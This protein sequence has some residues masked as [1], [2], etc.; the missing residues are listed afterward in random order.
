M[1]N[2][3]RQVG[4]NHLPQDKA[5][6][7]V[8]KLMELVMKLENEK[9]KAEHQLPAAVCPTHLDF[10][11]DFRPMS[12][13]EGG[14]KQSPTFPQAA[15]VASHESLNSMKLENEE[16]KEEHQHPAAAF[17]THLYFDFDFRPKWRPEQPA[18]PPPTWLRT[19][20]AGSA[21]RPQPPS[22]PLGD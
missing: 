20:A 18:F 19:T 1:A 17:T 6:V 22:F 9:G 15:D 16:G 2:G 3:G 14:W 12:L 5:S 8:Q 4:P 11:F 7:L 21:S 10:D 13:R